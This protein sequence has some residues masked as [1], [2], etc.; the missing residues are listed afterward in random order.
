MRTERGINFSPWEKEHPCRAEGVLGRRGPHSGLR[1][2]ILALDKYSGSGS[3]PPPQEG[4]FEEAERKEMTE[5]NTSLEQGFSSRC[6]NISPLPYIR[7]ST[8]ACTRS[9]QYTGGNGNLR[10][11]TSWLWRALA[12]WHQPHKW[13]HQL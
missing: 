7:I 3:R 9:K 10:Q 8:N 2:L 11:G 5:H 1:C 4:G 6:H 13:P 12:P